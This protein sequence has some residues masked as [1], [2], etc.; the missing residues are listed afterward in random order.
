MK[1]LQRGFESDIIW[2]VGHKSL[3]GSEAGSTDRA[4]G[5]KGPE[6]IGNSRKL[7][8]PNLEWVR[9]VAVWKS[10]GAKKLY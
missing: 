4:N 10:L 6:L 9:K 2:M 8:V 3:I 7:W 1:P 5:N